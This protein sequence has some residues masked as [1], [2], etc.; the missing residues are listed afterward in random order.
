MIFF[1]VQGDSALIGNTLSRSTT[2]VRARGKRFAGFV[3]NPGRKTPLKLLP[4]IEEKVSPRATQ[5]NLSVSGYIAILL[6]NQRQAPV[7]LH[8]E[9]DSPQ[10]TRVDLGLSWRRGLR[11]I[12]AQLAKDSGLSVNALTE[13]LIARDLRTADPVLVI[14]PQRNSP[15]P[16]L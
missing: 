5:L 3:S 1:S 15:K 12:A 6:W 13:A 10:M 14:L 8:A 4:K 9:P 16:R 2:I 7:R 11:S